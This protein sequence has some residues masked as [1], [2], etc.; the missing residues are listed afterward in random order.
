[1]PAMV[2][3]TQEEVVPIH[4]AISIETTATIETVNIP[5]EPIAETPHDEVVI[6]DDIIETVVM[7]EKAIKPFEG[8]IHDFIE[9]DAI[10]DLKVD[11]MRI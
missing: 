11:E 5:E 3:E 8:D 7:E 1:M 6:K 4:N 9:D 2:N 10:W